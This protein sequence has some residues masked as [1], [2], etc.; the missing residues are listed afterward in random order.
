[1]SS[2]APGQ[3][4]FCFGLK[5]KPCSPQQL[6]L[7]TLPPIFIVLMRVIRFVVVLL[8]ISALHRGASA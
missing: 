8:L 6:I 3:T 5:G 4:A 2:K 7:L 1:M